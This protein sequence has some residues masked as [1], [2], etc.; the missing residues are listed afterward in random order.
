M[1][2]TGTLTIR[3][4]SSQSHSPKLRKNNRLG[5]STYEVK[6]IEPYK[7]PPTSLA[8]RWGRKPATKDTSTPQLDA[9]LHKVKPNLTKPPIAG[10]HKVLRFVSE[11]NCE[12]DCEVFQNITQADYDYISCQIK[13]YPARPKLEYNCDTHT[14]VV[15]MPSPIHE[16]VI[17]AISKG[18]ECLDLLLQDFIVGNFLSSDTHTNLTID[19]DSVKCIPDIIHVVTA[20]TNPPILTTPVMGKVAVSQSRADLLQRLRDR[21]E[22]FPD[23]IL[24][25]MV[26]INE[27][28]PYSPP[29]HLSNA[30]QKLQ[31]GENAHSFTTIL[32]NHTGPRSLNTPTEIEVEGHLWH[33]MSSVH[34]QVWVQDINGQIDIDTQNPNL[35]TC[36]ELFLNESMDNVTL[37]MEMGLSQMR[38]QYTHL[39]QQVSPNIDVSALLATPVTLPFGWDG[40]LSKLALASMSMAH[41]HYKSWYSVVAG[42]RGVKRTAEE[43]F[44]AGPAKNTRSHMRAHVLTLLHFAGA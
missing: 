11:S 35:T 9:T 29:K 17:K 22:A 13:D 20:L 6:A 4:H 31:N 1:S 41:D 18:L 38:E 25:F 15:E 14:L 43:A 5:K 27:Q 30:W 28:I 36:G 37:M 44:D 21:V 10:R 23:I 3:S 7:Q 42:S 8:M 40:M 12:T 39:S 33:T 32:S 2:M 24:L 19:R 34:F 16:A 26:E